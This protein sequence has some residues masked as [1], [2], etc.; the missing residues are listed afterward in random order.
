MSN[1]QQ[2]SS[3]ALVEPK[4][5]KKKVFLTILRLAIS[6]G[7]LFLIFYAFR[8]KLVDVWAILLE[9]R[10]ELFAL[11]Y[12]F[13]ILSI[14]VINYRLKIVM[15]VN[16]MYIKFKP[17]F[18]LGMIGLFFNNILPS[19]VG[20]DAVKG[21]YL[22]KKTGRKLETF[23]TIFVDRII[24]LFTLIGLAFF[25]VLLFRSEAIDPRIKSVIYVLF[26][27]G[28]CLVL[29]FCS[30]RIARLFKFVWHMIPSQK[31]KEKLREVYHSIYQYKQ[32]PKTVI[33]SLVLSIFSQSLFIVMN[34]FLA[35]SLGV[36]APLGLFF[37]IMPIISSVSMA[38]SLN[39]LGVREGA[40]VYLFSQFFS[41]EKAFALSLL[42]FFVLLSFSLVGGLIYLFS[43]SIRTPHE[44]IKDELK[45]VRE[46][47][48]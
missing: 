35:L 24:G 9:T 41:S 20:G 2:L 17:V 15:T 13:Y 28:C 46:E 22:Y 7:A 10:W 32:H 40:Y 37:V 23:S 43:K 26:S 18:F 19:A 11:A 44:S 30:R 21:Y 6:F 29:F 25:A 36:S 45:H 27:G 38:P 39:G 42:F 34:Y 14:A 48:E 31:H 1:Q 5:E 8:S 12:A 33:Y 47:V 16:N 4:S 3:E